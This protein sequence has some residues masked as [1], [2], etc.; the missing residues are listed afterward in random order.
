MRAM[1]DGWTPGWS[2]RGWPMGQAS[3]RGAA[4]RAG[5]HSGDLAALRVVVRGGDVQDDGHGGDC[6]G[7]VVGLHAS[8]RWQAARGNKPCCSCRWDGE[9]A[10]PSLGA[11]RR[12]CRLTAVGKP[13]TA[14]RGAELGAGAEAAHMPQLGHIMAAPLTS[15]TNWGVWLGVSLPGI[16]WEAQWQLGFFPQDAGQL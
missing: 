9:C 4:G 7:I 6:D 11:R 12:H 2:G 15:T 1:N 10:A 8:Q 5:A 14:M 3:R 16:S 13:P